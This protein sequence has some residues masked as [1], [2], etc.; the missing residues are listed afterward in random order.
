MQ[1]LQVEWVKPH[2]D[3]VKVEDSTHPPQPPQQNKEI[4]TH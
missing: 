4:A 2:C 3:V 1:I